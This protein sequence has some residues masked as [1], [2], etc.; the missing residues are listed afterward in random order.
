MNKSDLINAISSRTQNSKTDVE[1]V[2]NAFISVVSE[3]ITEGEGIRIAGFGTLGVIK[4]KGR[5]GRNPL[6]G[7]KI[8]IESRYAPVFKAGKEL[9]E[10]ANRL[11]VD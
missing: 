1:K 8:F 10:A 3:N 4:R 2:V 11:R 7:E 6:T 5:N 9:R